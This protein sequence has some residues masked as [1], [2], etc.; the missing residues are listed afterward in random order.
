[1]NTSFIERHNATDRGRNAR[2]SRKTYRFSK[3]LQVHEA[4]TFLTMYSY[5][6]CWRVRALRMKKSDGRWQQRS[7]ALAARLT[8]YVWT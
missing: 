6:F 7:P 4:L 3:D 1:M 2:K 8:G 5:N